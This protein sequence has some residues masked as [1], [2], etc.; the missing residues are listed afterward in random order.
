[1]TTWLLKILDLKARIDPSHHIEEAKR[2]MF[3]Q[4]AVDK[5][6]EIKLKGNNVF[7]KTRIRSY[8]AKTRTHV[9]AAEDSAT[10]AGTS[11]L[12]L[13]AL[14]L[15]GRI[16]LEPPAISRMVASRWLAIAQDTRNDSERTAPTSESR[17][18][19]RKVASTRLPD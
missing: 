6:L 15:M 11:P 2:R 10:R 16:K 9:V 13:N 14:A 18:R 1:M 17:G 4:S 3:N 12:D 19:C 5:C 8:D 7:T